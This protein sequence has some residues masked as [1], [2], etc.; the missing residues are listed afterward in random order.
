APDPPRL[1]WFYDIMTGRRGALGE[2]A[3]EAAASE[4]AKHAAQA[5]AE[6]DAAPMDKPGVWRFQARALRI[7]TPD[8]P[9]AAVTLDGEPRLRTP[10]DV[11]VEPDALRVF[12]PAPATGAGGG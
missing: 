5:A 9:E 3:G 10:V 6:G 11:R 8:A 12:V 1:Q 7:S 4:A 2:G